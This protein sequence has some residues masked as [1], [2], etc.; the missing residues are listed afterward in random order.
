MQIWS[1][2]FGRD[3]FM[4]TQYTCDGANISPPLEW[5]D[6]PDDTQSLV[7]IVEDPDAPHGTFTHWVLYDLPTSCQALAENVD[8]AKLNGEVKQGKNDFAK[9]MYGGPC[10]PDGTHRY[11]FKLYALDQRLNLPAGASKADVLEAMNDHVL[12]S[13]TVMGQYTRQT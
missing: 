3:E 10:P 9:L 1:S 4:P 2:A 11:F 5:Q 12:D 7:L 6:L 13:A 8:L